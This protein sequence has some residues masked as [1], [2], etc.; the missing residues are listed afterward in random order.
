MDLPLI[1][2]LRSRLES[3]LL[4]LD[5][6]ASVESLARALGAERDVVSD[7][8]RA[9]QRELNNRGSGIELRET[10]EGWRFYTRSENAGA[11]EEFLLDGAQTKL[12]RA[13]PARA[14]A[15]GWVRGRE[16]GSRLRKQRSR[17]RRLGKCT[18]RPRPLRDGAR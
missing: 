16:P 11:V 9:V 12:S 5:S 18:Q 1:S 15:A 13:A 17:R 3:I 6:P 2:Q 7:C 4:V 10:Q 8:L 14:R